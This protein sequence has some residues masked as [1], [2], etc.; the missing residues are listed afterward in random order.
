[1]KR[2]MIMTITTLFLFARLSAT[3]TES[4]EAL[5]I[6]RDKLVED[7]RQLIA[8]L[9]DTH[10]DPYSNGGG[11]I[12]FH[13]RFQKVLR[14]IPEGGMTQRQFYDILLPLVSAIGDSHTGILIQKGVAVEGPGLPWGLKIIEENLIVIT[15][16]EQT[17]KDLIG[18]KIVSV[19]GATMDELIKRQSELRGIENI[20]GKLVLLSRNLGTR[21]GLRD[22]LPGWEDRG[23]ITVKLLLPSGKEEVLDVDIT[24]G[25]RE[26]IITAESEIEM[27]S[28]EKSDVSYCFADREK[29][30]AL[31]VI[32]DMMKYREGCEAWFA[33]GLSEAAYYSGLAYRHFHGEEPPADTTAL[34]SGIPSVTET[35]L[36][37]VHEMRK[38]GTVNLIIDLRK[39]TGGNSI[40][41]EI[42][43]YFL[44]GRKALREMDNGYSIPRYSRL[45]F[46]SYSSMDLNQINDGR[47]IPLHLGDYDLSE[48][49]EYFERRNASGSKKKG[50]TGYSNNEW[51]SEKNLKKIPSFAKVFETGKYDK[52]LWVPKNIFALCSPWTFSSGFNMLTALRNLGAVTVGTPPGQPGNNFGDMLMFKLKHSAI[53]G[54]VS[55]KRVITF[56]DDP[57]KGHCLMPDHVLTYDR[58]AG[59]GFDPNSEV[60]LALEI[61]A[62]S[63]EIMR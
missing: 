62:G 12:A 46:D 47:S 26:G 63:E 8:I 55:F 23:I 15:V 53:Q 3:Q 36:D 56:P 37:L 44:F 60:R 31:L 61:L 28:M 43:V 13:R 20:Y 7:A 38:A 6:P 54:F 5:V 29:E 49:R 51:S 1:M 57:T 24:E 11:K 17:S 58:F 45:Y 16:P 50:S 59:F 32:A 42:L 14:S 21:Q 34:L 19:G 52:P 27:P 30:T 10:P 18:A 4:R 41:R 9:E 40:M 2:I 22:L 48:E 35:F 33:D 25:A 39:N